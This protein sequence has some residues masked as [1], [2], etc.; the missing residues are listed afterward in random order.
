MD[1]HFDCIGRNYDVVL[2]ST[3]SDHG[4]EEMWFYQGDIGGTLTIFL[5]E[6]GLPMNLPPDGKVMCFFERKDKNIVQRE[7]QLLT[8]SESKYVATIDN[9]ILEVAGKVK[10]EV[11]VYH[12]ENRTTLAT[13]EIT[14]KKSMSI[15]GGVD[16]PEKYD[17]IQTV[18]QQGLRLDGVDQSLQLNQEAHDSFVESLNAHQQAIDN[19]RQ[20]L[21]DTDVKIDNSVEA[22]NNSIAETNTA[23]DNKVSEIN[24][25]LD[26]LE[27]SF[28]QSLSTL[29]N[30]V[31]DNI[32]DTNDKIS[33]LD[34]KTAN[35]FEEFNNKLLEFETATGLKFE[36]VLKTYATLSNMTEQTFH[37]VGDQLDTLAVNKVSIIE[38][39]EEPD[40]TNLPVGTLWI[41]PQ[42]IEE[43]PE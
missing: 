40:T 19:I 41:K 35:S 18:M 16:T 15:E 26:Q 37:W 30:S 2:D 23:M 8:R 36:D 38:S 17:L 21:N 7:L 31:A 9:A 28:S 10:C 33:Q 14:S 4:L 29:A 6:A 20:L 12:C 22:V 39:E 27:Q 34:T 43:K 1:E 13:F 32:A 5:H 25:A 24:T 11:K 42:I 3:S